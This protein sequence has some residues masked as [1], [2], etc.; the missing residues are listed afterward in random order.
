MTGIRD[1]ADIKIGDT[2][3]LSE[4]PADQMLPGYKDVRPM[5]LV[6]FIPWTLQ[7]MKN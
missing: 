4:S 7:I 6:G 1:V 3:T 2:L 5:V